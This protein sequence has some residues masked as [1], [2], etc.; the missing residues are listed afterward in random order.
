MR[1]ITLTVGVV[2]KLRILFACD[3]VTLAHFSG[4]RYRGA[5]HKICRG[6]RI[7]VL[8]A[9]LTFFYERIECASQH[10]ASP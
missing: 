4:D 2:T 9:P 5:N 3:G 6:L 7:T 10:R 1:L 8:V